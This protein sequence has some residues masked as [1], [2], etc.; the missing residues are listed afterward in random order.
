MVKFIRYTDRMK[1]NPNYSFTYVK[2]DVFNVF[3]ELDG[4][5]LGD[6]HVSRIQGNFKLSDNQL[7]YI[8]KHGTTNFIAVKSSHRKAKEKLG[9][10]ENCGERK[11]G[12][13]YS[14]QYEEFLCPECR[15][16]F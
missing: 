3:N 10:C 5:D 13:K 1:Q 9:K 15:G 7:A 2:K 6:H 16:D 11:D 4:V 8:K 14:S 12:V